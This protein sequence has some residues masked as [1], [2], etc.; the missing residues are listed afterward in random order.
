MIQKQYEIGK[1][2]YDDW[3]DSQEKL[4][5]AEIRV[6]QAE[7]DKYMSLIDLKNKIGE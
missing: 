2:K 4:T 7:Q 1:A 6:I 3:S 5:E